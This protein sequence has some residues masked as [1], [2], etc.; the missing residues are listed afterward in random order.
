MQGSLLNS[1]LALGASSEGRENV[2]EVSWLGSFRFPRLLLKQS[3]ASVN[4]TA[5][6]V[7]AVFGVRTEE[8]GSLADIRTEI[9]RMCSRLELSRTETRSTSFPVEWIS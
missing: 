9:V 2:S 3:W 4:V 6:G 5:L 8:K 1:T 7:L